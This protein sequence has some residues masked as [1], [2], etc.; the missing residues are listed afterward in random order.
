MFSAALQ[1]KS[2]EEF[3]TNIWIRAMRAAIICVESKS[4]RGTLGTNSSGGDLSYY[5]EEQ[6]P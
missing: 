5:K 3:H 2:G 1:E 4:V 6:I